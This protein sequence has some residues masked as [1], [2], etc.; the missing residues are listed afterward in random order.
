MPHRLPPLSALRAFEAAARHLSFK[1][2][3]AELHVSPAAISHQIHALEGYL[4]APLF[5]RLNRGLNLTD[6][7]RAALPRISD[8]FQSLGAGVEL[9]RATDAGIILSVR[10]GP[11]LAAK[12]LVPR[13]HRFAAANPGVD[14][15]IAASMHAVDGRRAEAQAA[16]E[17]DDESPA[18]VDVQIRFGSGSYPGYTVDKLLP[19]SLTPVCS[20]ALLTSK[21]AL[22]T[23]HDLC[24]HTL[25]HDDALGAQEGHPD[26]SMWLRHAG[27]TEVNPGRGSH[28]THSALALQ[29][30]A[31]GLGV[32][33]AMDVLA[34]EDVAAGR[35][36]APFALKVLLPL[37]Y[38]VV[39]PAVRSGQPQVDAF[40]AWLLREAQPA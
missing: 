4:G 9:M 34:A 26:W 8:G 37:A 10:S 15:R 25:L 28:F 31:D 17:A 36:V 14:V 2:A 23:A 21:H 27:A 32:A 6:I 40:R 12:W 30:A 13:L 39:A 7:A 3:A 33:L 11:A 19:V 24:H 35:L 29:A 1:K 16:D 22:R 5:E 20:P 38:Y 18:D